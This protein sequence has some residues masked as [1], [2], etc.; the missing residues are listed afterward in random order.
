MRIQCLLVIALLSLPAFG[1]ETWGLV[2][3]DGNVTVYTKLLPGKPYKSFKAVGVVQSTPIQLLEILENVG[4]Y[5]QWFAYS[6]SVRLLDTKKNQQYVYMQTNFPW[7]FRNEDMVYVISV[8]DSD[9]GEIKLLLEGYPAFIPLVDGVERMRG[10]NGYILLQ[11]EHEHT[12]VT[13]V[14]H[15]ELS[16]HILPW[17]ANKNIQNM[18]FRTLNNLIAIAEACQPMP[19]C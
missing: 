4:R 9:D 8:T 19:G 2:K 5:N 6:H 1:Q 18:P 17:L 15:I 3:S 12:I 16:G 11:P 14:M 13:Y 7:P 10:A